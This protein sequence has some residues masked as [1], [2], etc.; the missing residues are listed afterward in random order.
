MVQRHPFSTVLGILSVIFFPFIFLACSPVDEYSFVP[1]PYQ[2]FVSHEQ[3]IYRVE[4][5]AIIA[6]RDVVASVVPSIQ[7]EL[8]FRTAGRI[9]RITVSKGDFV[10]KGDLLAEMD[11]EDQLNQLQQAQIVLSS[12]QTTLARQ[13]IQQQTSIEKAEIMLDSWKKQYQQVRF[14]SGNSRADQL[15]EEIVAAN[16]RLAEIAVEEAR[17]SIDPTLAQAVERNQLN[18]QRLQALVEE[19]QII[20]PYDGVIVN[21]SSVPGSDIQAFR[22]LV[23]IGNPAGL[24]IR[25]AVIVDLID[26]LNEQSEVYLYLSPND[27]AGYRTTF[28]PDFRLSSTQETI[29]SVSPLLKF[30]YFSMP[31]N[32][33]PNQIQI[34]Y[35]LVLKIISGKKENALLLPTAAL[36]QFHNLHYV[37]VL[38][39]G[40]HKRVQLDGV[41]LRTESKVEVMGDLNEGQEVLA[42]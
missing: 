34:G 1:T 23:T 4:R 37:I 41:G 40:L 24:V 38:E 16:V 20:A 22:V 19:R 42:P 27:S 28:L 36:R 13:Q 15:N 8:S 12:S 17:Q 39:N 21:V 9:N 31:K 7:D 25:A 3:T 18:V 2:P 14:Q 6:T 35:P 29:S 30:F 26:R 10:K 32:I 11:V 33:P 5:G